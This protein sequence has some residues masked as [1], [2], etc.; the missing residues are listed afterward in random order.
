MPSSYAKTAAENALLQ[1]RIEDVTPAMWDAMMPGTAKKVAALEKELSGFKQS[2]P[3]AAT[4]G[5]PA[6]APVAP[7]GR[8]MDSMFADIAKRGT[9]G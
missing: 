1:G 3:A 6:P 2:S 4:N 5:A 7:T 8:K 9:A